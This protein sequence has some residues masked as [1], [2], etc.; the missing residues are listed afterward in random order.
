[1]IKKKEFN[2]KKDFSTLGIKNREIAL[3]NSKSHT[4]EKSNLTKREQTKA[5]IHEKD[6]TKITAHEKID[7]KK[8]YPNIS[9]SLVMHL[10]QE[11]INFIN[12]RLEEHICKRIKGV[13]SP[14]AKL[15]LKLGKI[16]KN[17]TGEQVKYITDI[18][19]DLNYILENSNFRRISPK[20]GEH[21]NPNLQ[22]EID[23]S[24]NAKYNELD[25]LDILQDGFF[26]EFNQ[27]IVLKPKVIVNRRVS[28]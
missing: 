19:D 13:L 8:E 26:W 12:H 25:I 20:V 6:Q 7:I 4:D 27:E 14:V 11:I 22:E 17:F 5:I 16:R 23:F 1:M 24:W 21:Y 15:S 18:E 9:D 2:K 10:E 3:H 28:S